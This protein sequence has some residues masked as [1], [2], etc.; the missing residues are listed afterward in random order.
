M[1][2]LEKVVWRW[3]NFAVS[4]LNVI[5]LQLRKL[6]LNLF[7]NKLP[8]VHNPGL[9]KGHKFLWPY[10][11]FIFNQAVFKVLLLPYEEFDIVIGILDLL[12][13]LFGF[14]GVDDLVNYPILILILIL[15]LFGEL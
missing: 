10:N 5:W 6:I 1:V 15:R 9:T 11:N 13:L 8:D 4:N 12:L 2:L 3:H 14:V 7:I